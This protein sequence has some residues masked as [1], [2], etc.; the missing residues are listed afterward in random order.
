M[1]LWWT[2]PTFDF[3]RLAGRLCVSGFPATLYLPTGMCEGLQSVARP[4]CSKAAAL[5]AAVGSLAIS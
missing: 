4:E 3:S 1:I 5:Q 2:S